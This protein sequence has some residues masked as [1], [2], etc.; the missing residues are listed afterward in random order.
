M[1]VHAIVESGD[2]GEEFSG[3]EESVNEIN[4]EVENIGNNDISGESDEDEEYKEVEVNDKEESEEIPSF[5]S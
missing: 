3:E 2:D 5:K 1:D 4:D